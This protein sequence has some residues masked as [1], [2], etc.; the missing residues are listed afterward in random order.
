MIY[1]NDY[2][3][4]DCYINVL[5]IST[6]SD[7][8]EKVVPIYPIEK[9]IYNLEAFIDGW[10]CSSSESAYKTVWIS[11]FE[12]F[13]RS[14]YPEPIDKKLG[15]VDMLYI[16][17]VN[18]YAAFELFYNLYNKF[19][20]NIQCH[21]KMNDI[22]HYRCNKLEELCFFLKSDL[23]SVIRAPRYDYLIDFLKG[24]REGL[25]TQEGRDLIT[26][27][28]LSLN[29]FKKIIRDNYHVE[30]NEYLGL[31]YNEGDYANS[32]RKFIIYLEKSLELDRLG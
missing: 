15:W 20:S 8:I 2:I 23:L 7:C 18:E 4:D 16:N 32:I 28:D 17:S 11:Q 19:K 3:Y 22:S 30:K 12:L 21:P 13:V 24:W 25:L 14:C 5:S 10:I 29:K 9:S 1:N 31:L 26:K 6:F 27:V